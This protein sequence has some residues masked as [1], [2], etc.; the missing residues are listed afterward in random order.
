MR[1]KY[2]EHPLDITGMPPG[3]PNIVG[4]EG[5]ERFSFYGMK[6]IL[7]VFMTTYLVNRL[8]Q[9]D[10]MTEEQ[11]KS[12]FHLFTSAVYGLSFLGAIISDGFLGKYRTIMYLSIVY[13]FG[14][15][16]L[17]LDDTRLGLAVGLTLIALG[18]GGIKPCVSAHVGDQ[19]GARNENLRERVFSW[20]YLA[21][22]LGALISMLLTPWLLANKNYG[23]SWAFGVP[24]IAMALATLVFWMGRHRFAHIP[25]G[26]KQFL[27]EMFSSEGLKAIGK[28]VPVY[29]FVAIFW[30]LYDQTGSAWVLQAQKMDLN[31]LGH[32]WLPSQVQAVNPLLI[33]ILAPAF[34]YAVYPVMGR[35]FGL[36]PLRKL[37]IGFVLC[38]LSFVITAWV[39]ARI[40]A[41]ETPNIGWQILG[42]VVITAAEVLV[43]ITCL[44]FS[45]SQA[46]KKMKSL[47][48]ALFLFSVSLGNLVTSGV[49]VF[50]QNADGTTK[51]V[52]AEYY[53]FFA[54]L[55]AV[56]TLIW[57]PVAKWYP[58][59]TYVA[60][61]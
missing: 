46:P 58:E 59:K 14:H 9:P 12:W 15:L 38:I 33:L 57:I 2:R 18:S 39:E 8:G 6:G 20:F 5:A 31:F 53:V 47:V 23:P 13:C 45:Y 44:D 1:T 56:A 60:G 28:L 27:K 54:V 3:I 35:L 52:G 36:T 61:E 32:T 29:A 7:T 11:A 22:N 43:S 21:I 26:G 48:M 55:M 41:G 49:N 42:Y 19:F 17:A 34:A 30:A 16:A 51:L 37:G 10:V 24:G 50:I 40:T 4:N 25:A